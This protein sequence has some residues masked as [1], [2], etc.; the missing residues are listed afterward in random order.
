MIRNPTVMLFYVP[1]QQLF[2]YWASYLFYIQSL[3]NPSFRFGKEEWLHNKPGILYLLF[4][5]VMVVTDKFVLKNIFPV[6]QTDRILT[7]EQLAGFFHAGIF[8]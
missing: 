5:I 1:F 3:L 6:N 8:C 7:G 4:S 2:F